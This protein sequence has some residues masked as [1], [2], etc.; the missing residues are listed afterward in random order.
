MADVRE[1]YQYTAK[2]QLCAVVGELDDPYCQSQELLQ[3]DF[4]NGGNAVIYGVAGSGKEN[5]LSTMLYSMYLD[6]DAKK[7]NT[8]ILDFGAETLRMFEN[9]PQTGAV[10]VDGEDDKII[11]RAVA[12]YAAARFFWVI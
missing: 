4:A 7:L 2:E 6:Y 11:N 3:I 5:F 12:K 10:V 9:A 1:K 8:Y